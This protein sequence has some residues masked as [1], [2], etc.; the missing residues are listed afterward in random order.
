MLIPLR[1]IEKLKPTWRPCRR[2]TTPLALDSCA[3]LLPPAI[4]MPAPMAE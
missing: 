2:S 3:V 1:S 4:D